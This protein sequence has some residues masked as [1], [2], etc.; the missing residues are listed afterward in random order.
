VREVAEQMSVSGR[1]LLI[2]GDA[3]HVADEMA[4]WMRD[5]GIDGFNLARVLMPQ[6]FED[7]IDL[8]IPKLQERGLYKTAYRSGTMREKL[9]VGD[10]AHLSATHAGRGVLAAA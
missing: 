4:S 6:S 1:N 7:F 8:V 10:G 5:T 3:D 2:V 9:R